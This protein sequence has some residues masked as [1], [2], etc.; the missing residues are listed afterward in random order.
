MRSF[1][2]IA[3]LALICGTF[4]MMGGWGM[5]PGMGMGMMP[6]MGMMWPGMCGCGMGCC[7]MGGMGMGMG[8]WSMADNPAARR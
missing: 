2:L 7:G 6:G 1:L 8:G 3:F 4:A 5:M